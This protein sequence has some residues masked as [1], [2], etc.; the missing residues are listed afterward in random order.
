M[1]RSS[2]ARARTRR[3]SVPNDAARP[4]TPLKLVYSADD[5]DSPAILEPGAAP[6]LVVFHRGY[7]CA[8]DGQVEK[9]LD[10]FREALALKPDF[11]EAHYNLGV[12]FDETE[13]FREA[14]DA[15]RNSIVIKPDFA[16]AY[17]N[18][19]LT[20][21]TT[22]Q[23]PEAINACRKAIALN[24]DD[25]AAYYNLGRMLFEIGQLQ[26]AIAAYRKATA[27]EPDDADA[28]YYLG[29]TL[30]ATRQFPE[31]VAAY[32]EAIALNPDDAAAYSYLGLVLAETGQ[33]V[34]AIATCRK[35]VA[36]K[37]N[38]VDAH[39]NLGVV[40]AKAGQFSEAVVILRKARKIETSINNA[41][42]IS[43]RKEINSLI[44]EYTAKQF[45]VKTQGYTV[46][47]P[48]SE[49][50]AIEPQPPM[51]E[52]DNLTEALARAKAVSAA[53][54]L[55]AT[56]EVLVRHS[57]L[58]N[59]ALTEEDRLRRAEYLLKTYKRLRKAKPDFHDS[60]DQLRVARQVTQSAYRERKRAKLSGERPAVSV[61]RAAR[62]P[63]LRM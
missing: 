47:S 50:A 57:D 6:Y 27:L 1:A 61:S 17:Y 56:Y 32:R 48:S 16:E 15:Y 7:M 5:L 52:K 41:T 4:R 38:V 49:A 36:L 54:R 24:P 19:G 34:E 60:N 26:E 58:M 30:A 37:P 42:G 55:L 23:L 40:L 33:F 11:A 53:E 18:L 8:M 43:K 10:L 63:K 13:Q 12:M 3:H 59:P 25:A 22:G 39:F 62:A 9:A 21:A 31:A 20:L 14:I 28:H 2:T 45:G 35:A 29:L 44:K 51:G 46:V